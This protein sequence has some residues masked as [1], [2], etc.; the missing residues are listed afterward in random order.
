MRGNELELDLREVGILAIEGYNTAK[1]WKCE[2]IQSDPQ[3]KGTVHP[4]V[5][6][7]H[8]LTVG[9]LDRQVKLLVRNKVVIKLHSTLVSFWSTMTY[10]DWI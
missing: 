10:W 3:S 9:L 5:K 2:L 4:K 8:L 1:V 6:S 7:Y